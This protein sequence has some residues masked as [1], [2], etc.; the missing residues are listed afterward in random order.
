MSS[1]N[2]L[3]SAARDTTPPL[4]TSGQ[5]PNSLRSN[6]LCFMAPAIE[7]RRRGKSKTR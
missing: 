3:K 2:V 6:R 7:D 5:R 1:V 4:L